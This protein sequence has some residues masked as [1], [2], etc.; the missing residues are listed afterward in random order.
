MQTVCQACF[1]LELHAG[2]VPSTQ[3]QVLPA[4]QCADSEL[5]KNLAHDDMP[6]RLVQCFRLGSS[7]QKLVVVV[8]VVQTTLCRRTR[9]G[10]A[11]AMMPAAVRRRRSLDQCGSRLSPSF[12]VRN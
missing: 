8:V 5:E 7:D 12:R 6:F 3:V 10:Q 1:K 9:T 4:W 2:G 11:T